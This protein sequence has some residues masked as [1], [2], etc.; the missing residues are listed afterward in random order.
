MNL[1]TKYKNSLRQN[2]RIVGPIA[3][4]AHAQVMDQASARMP[5][6]Q[7]P[8]FQVQRGTAALSQ[9]KV[10]QPHVKA[11]PNSL[12]KAHPHIKVS[13][14]VSRAH[15]VTV[16][17]QQNAAPNRPNPVRSGERP[18]STERNKAVQQGLGA[19][20]PPKPVTNIYELLV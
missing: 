6:Q 17:P 16:Q 9:V 2:A 8:A 4:Q 18:R 13:P 11:S 7:R 5:F 19:R 20:V 14:N 3:N 10:P 12:H 15:T 1:T